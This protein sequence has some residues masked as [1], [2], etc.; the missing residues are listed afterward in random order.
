MS[1][2]L[3]R[4]STS[5]RE[6]TALTLFLDLGS[7]QAA[8]AMRVSL[9]TLRRC[10]AEA[11]QR[12]K[13]FCLQAPE[14][15]LFRDRQRSPVSQASRAATRSPMGTLAQPGSRGKGGGVAGEHVARSNDVYGVHGRVRQDAAP[16]AEAPAQRRAGTAPPRP[17][18]ASQ[19][20][21]I[22]PAPAGAPRRNG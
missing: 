17:S 12:P 18:Q 13:P 20:T 2:A 7:G 6:A 15:Q 19:P 3:R 16:S 4:L 9:A 22:V 8:A 14:C 11:G 10:L 5:Q 1:L 21:Q